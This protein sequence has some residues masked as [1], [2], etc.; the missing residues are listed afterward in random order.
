MFAGPAGLLVDRFDSR[1]VVV[2]AS[3]A[4]AVVAVGLALTGA[5]GAILALTALLGVANA[6]SQPAEFALIPAVVTAKRLPTANAHVETA[7]FAGFAAGPL[8]GDILAGVSGTELP[9]LVNA[10]TFAVIAVAVVLLR[11]SRAAAS[12]TDEPLGRA[13]DGIVF[14]TSDK[15]LGLVMRVAFASLLFMTASAPA[16]V[17]FA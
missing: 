4:Q 16:E 17:F 3:V 12:V 10:A 14:L 6:V 7:R 15:V 1:R 8:L 2:A 9:M 5:L 13:R 11:P